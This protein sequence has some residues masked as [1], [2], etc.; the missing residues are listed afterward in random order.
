M[1]VLSEDAQNITIPPLNTQEPPKKKKQN[2]KKA[3]PKQSKPEFEVPEV[4]PGQTSP[5]FEKLTVLIELNNDLDSDLVVYTY[6]LE[7]ELASAKKKLKSQ[8]QKFRQ[9]IHWYK[10]FCQFSC[11]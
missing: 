2:R 6:K 1:E 7:A 9:L 3:E 11:L 10:P 4:I 8:R 5:I